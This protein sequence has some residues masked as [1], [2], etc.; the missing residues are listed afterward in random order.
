MEANSEAITTYQGENPNEVAYMA[1]KAMRHELS[2]R[3]RAAKQSTA[4]A[5][6]DMNEAS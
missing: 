1:D 6:D 5:V 2:Y 3:R 4:N